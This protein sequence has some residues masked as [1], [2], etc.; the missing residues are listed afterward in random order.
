VYFDCQF[1][2]SKTQGGLSAKMT[3]KLDFQCSG[4]RSEIVVPFL[5]GAGQLVQARPF[6][7]QSI[8]QREHGKKADDGQ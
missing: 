4:G 5:D 3:K 8:E 6:L 1:K 7:N 2:M